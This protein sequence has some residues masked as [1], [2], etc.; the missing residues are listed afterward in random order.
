[1][2]EQANQTQW[3]GE[4]PFPKFIIANATTGDSAD[5]VS[6]ISSSKTEVA[7]VKG[8]PLNCKAIWI[9]TGG[10]IYI[11]RNG[12]KGPALTNVQSGF[13]PA[14]R[15]LANNDSIHTDSTASDMVAV[16]W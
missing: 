1:M 7:I 11:S 14:A 2:T 4:V 16:N 10:T 8:T 3:I 6:M 15:S 9:G 13:F 12:V 5:G